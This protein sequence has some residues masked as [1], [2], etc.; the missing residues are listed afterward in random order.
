MYNV[1]FQIEGEQL[2]ILGDLTQEA[3]VSASGKSVM[4][5]TT[6]GNVSVPGCEQ[7][8]VGLNVYRPQQARRGS[9]RMA[10]RK[11]EWRG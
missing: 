2:V 8:K 4:I 11:D 3:G 6:S 5:A 7:V 10:S 1:Q 9:G